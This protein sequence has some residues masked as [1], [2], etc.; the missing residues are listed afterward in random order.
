M[1]DN[2]RYPWM[3]WSVECHQIFGYSA[4][5]KTKKKGVPLLDCRWFG[6]LKTQHSLVS[7]AAVIYLESDDWAGTASSALSQNGVNSSGAPVIAWNAEQSPSTISFLEVVSTPRNVASFTARQTC[8]LLA[9]VTSYHNVA[10]AS[11]LETY[12]PLLCAQS[13]VVDVFPCLAY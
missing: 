2:I 5:A 6:K 13:M 10:M 4:I 8:Q 1:L 12:S 11:A 9:G 3:V 7:R